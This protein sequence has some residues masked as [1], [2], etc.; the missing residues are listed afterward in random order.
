PGYDAP[1]RHPRREDAAVGRHGRVDR[2]R[3][4]AWDRPRDPPAPLSTVRNGQ[5]HRPGLG[6]RGVA[7][8]RRGPR[9][10]DLRRQPPNGRRLLLRPA[11]RPRARP[12]PTGRRPT[13]GA[14]MQ[15]LLLIDDEPA[16]QHA[17]RRAF[18]PPGYQTVTARSAEEG[19][20]LL[21]SYRPDV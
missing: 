10:K 20:Q 16:I 7:A 8:D 11:A 2:H 12:D 21:D 17:F 6:P 19:L 5:G 1:R 18:H 13:S 14:D 9:R 4:G 15:T 3:H